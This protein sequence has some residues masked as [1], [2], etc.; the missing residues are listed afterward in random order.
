MRSIPL[1]AATLAALRS[2]HRPLV[3][4]EAV[5]AQATEA[6]SKARAEARRLDER[7]VKIPGEVVAGRAR[8]DEVSSTLTAARTAALL[9][10]PLEQAVAA[11]EARVEQAIEGALDAK[12]KSIRDRRA[13]L[14]AELP[15]VKVKDLQKYA[16]EDRALYFAALGVVDTHG[17]R[18]LDGKDLGAFLA[19]PRSFSDE[20]DMSTPVAGMLPSEVAANYWPRP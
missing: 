20:A 3:A 14:C 7:A 15:G 16:D 11:A 19:W 8:P 17:R 12:A 5:L 9:I 2:T 4:A 10:P 18:L 6:L 1:T 13:V